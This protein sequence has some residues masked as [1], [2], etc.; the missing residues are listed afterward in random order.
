MIV[1][2]PTNK[3]I[4]CVQTGV[5]PQEAKDVLER[6]HDDLYLALTA[7]HFRS[8]HKVASHTNWLQN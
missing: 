4:I 6:Y 3:Q 1:Q 7:I 2:M 8:L 5:T